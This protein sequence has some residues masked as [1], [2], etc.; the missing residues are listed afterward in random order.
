M[1]FDADTGAVHFDDGLAV[2]PSSTWADLEPRFALLSSHGEHRSV[3]RRATIGGTCFSVVAWFREDVLERV[4]LTVDEPEISGTSWSDYDAETAR[5]FH[6]EWVTSQ[7]GETTAW[8]PSSY[9]YGGIERKYRW[10]TIGSHVHPQD[11][12]ASITIAYGR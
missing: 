8:N 4:S 12:A 2:G 11:G 1:A 7:V 5:R 6:D 10:G 9:P 3:H